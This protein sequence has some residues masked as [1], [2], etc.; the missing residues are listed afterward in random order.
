MPSSDETF[1]P[2]LVQAAR[3]CPPMVVRRWSVPVLNL[4]GSLVCRFSSAGDP[5]DLGDVS[6]FMHWPVQPRETPG[7]AIL[8]LHGGGLL[9]GD[10]RQD[11]SLI[12]RFVDELGVPV[13]SVQYRLAGAHPFPA[14]LD[15]CRSA[16]DWL[17]ARPDVDPSMIAVLGIS[18]G[19]G[20]AAGLAQLC[21]GSG[22]VEPCLQVLVYP[23]LDDRSSDAPHPDEASY[24]LWD[25]RSNRLGWGQYLRGH[26]QSA[27]PPCAV[28]SRMASLE[29]LPPA[30]IGVGTCDLFHDED[31]AYARRL[32]ASGVPTELVVVEGGF[33]AFDTVDPEADVSRAFFRSQVGAIRSRF[34]ALGWTG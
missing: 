11:A 30:W 32:E 14:P 7:P 2:D 34:L 28:P 3:R 13:C 15:D 9:V 19:G 29:G 1:H 20:L 25:R 17:A 10:A 23:M 6:V 4:L 26:D 12:R 27:P 33:H 8:W 22:G 16:L 31:L 5:V 24:R 18:A 21:R